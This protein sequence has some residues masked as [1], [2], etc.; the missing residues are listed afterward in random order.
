MLFCKELPGFTTGE[1][2]FKSLD[3]FI[4]HNL[5]WNYCVSVCTDGA[6][7]MT[8]R[9]NGLIAR[10]KNINPNIRANHCI[11]HRQA[12]ASKKISPELNDTMN[13][14]I[15]VV[16]FMKSKALNSRLFSVLCEE[17]GTNHRCLLLH[18]EIRWLSRGRVVQ[19]IFE[20]RDEVKKFLEE[21]N[22]QYFESLNDS[23]FIKV[24]YL[25]DIFNQINSLNLSLQKDSNI[26][27]YNSAIKGF[28]KKLKIWAKKV[29]IDNHE[30]FPILKNFL[31]NKDLQF[32]SIKL[33]VKR[34]LEELH[35]H[36]DEYFPELKEKQN[37]EWICN[38][39][40]ANSEEQNL[41]ADKEEELVELS[42]NEKYKLLFK[43]TNLVSFWL[44]LKDKYPLISAEA[45]SYL[46]PFASTYL[47]ETSFSALTYLKNKYKTKLNVENDLRLASLPQLIH[48]FN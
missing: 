18:S 21:R 28:M 30:M 45:I 2:I 43:S 24:S 14:V 33:V 10:I 32:S 12:L 25:A 8:G 44:Q 15:N 41:S 31:E 9:K 42:C 35:K 5:D 19:R 6:A 26:I 48:S 4:S 46:L 29:D 23:F 17:V 1:E 11:I 34:H 7:S 36:F 40:A 38:P 37:D 22:F 47:C 20:L 13:L 3:D 27:D 39:F 16:N